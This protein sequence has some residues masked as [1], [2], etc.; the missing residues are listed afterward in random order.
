MPIRT[1]NIL[2]TLIALNR[3]AS[4]VGI[5]PLLNLSE[6]ST[7]PDFTLAQQIL[8]EITQTT[9]SQGL[10]CNT[11]YNVTLTE[12]DTDGFTIIPAGALICDIIDHGYVERDG[13]VYSIK[14]NA[15][16]TLTT[17]K[18]EI[19]DNMTYD[20]LPELVKSYIAT[21]AARSFI[22]RVKGDGTASQITIPDES[23]IAQEFHRY[24]YNVGDYTILDGSLPFQIARSG[25]NYFGSGR[26]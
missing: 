11:R 7:E 6:V 15:P 8:D 22:A 19:V 10:P 13:L 24:V 18:A 5:P 20:D 21:R 9:L 23:R 12:V 4:F 17:L 25:R 26:Y 2:D 14:E 16:T 3:M 1:N